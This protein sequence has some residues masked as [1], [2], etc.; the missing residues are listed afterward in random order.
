MPKETTQQAA[1][2]YRE[3]FDS[4]DPEEIFL[5]E[6]EIASGSF[7]AVYKVFQARSNIVSQK[8]GK[9]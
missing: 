6:E 5:L 9:T 2:K 1:Q 7:G 8:L 4:G 3:Y